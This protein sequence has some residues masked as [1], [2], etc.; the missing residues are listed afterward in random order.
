[1]SHQKYPPSM[2]LFIMN[3]NLNGTQIRSR[4]MSLF[5]RLFWS[6]QKFYIFLLYIVWNIPEI[7]EI[8]HCVFCLWTARVMQHTAPW[9][10]LLLPLLKMCRL[11]SQSVDANH[12]FSMEKQP[13][14]VT[15]VCNSDILDFKQYYIWEFWS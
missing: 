7:L 13:Y 6:K 14:I 9:L 11:R 2:S 3:C 4:P 15:D 1:M 5:W 8:L 12:D 10:K